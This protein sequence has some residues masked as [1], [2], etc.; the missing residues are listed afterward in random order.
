MPNLD[1][2]RDRELTPKNS[3]RYAEKVKL[4]NTIREGYRGQSERADDI[5]DFWSIYNCEIDG[6]NFYNGSSNIY[7]P[8]V[9]VGLR[10]LITRLLNQLFPSS[11]RYIDASSSDDELPHAE[12]AL[13]EDYVRRTYLRTDTIPALLLNGLVEGQYN[14]YND[15]NRSSRWVVTRDTIRPHMA[16]QGISNPLQLPDMD[17]EPIEGITIEEVFDQMPCCEVIHDID[18]LV[19]PQTASS[20]D[21]A[22]QQGGD[23]TI[24]RRWTK[25][26]I[27]D[28]MERGELARSPCEKLLEI[29]DSSD[30]NDRWRGTEKDLMDAAGIRIG[31]GGMKVFQV[32]ETWKVVDVPGEGM[33]LTKSY[34]GGYEI[35][36]SDRLNPMWNDRCQLLSAP[37]EKVGSAFKGI[38]RIKSGIASLQ[39]YANQIAQQAADS[40]TYSMLPIVMTDPA[41]NPRT[42]T[43]LLNVGA[44]WEIDPNSTKFAQFPPIWK[45]AT[46]I[47]QDCIAQIFQALGVNP[48]M[49]PQQTG[50]PGRKRNQAETALEQQVDLLSNSGEAAIVEDKILTPTV[51]MW[52]EYDHQF[53][54][55]ESTVRAYGS[56]GQVANMQKVP[57]LQS[58]TRYHFLWNGVQQSRNAAEN[59]QRI[60][61]LNVAMAPPMQQ[62]LVSD[63]KRLRVAPAL[64]SAFG[65]LFGWREGRK[66]LVDISAVTMIKPEEENGM[67]E[68]HFA[69]PVHPMDDFAKHMQIHSQLLQSPDPV[70]SAITRDHMQLHVMQRNQAMMAQQAQQQGPP[71]GQQGGGPTPPMQGGNAAG[72]RLVRG[73]PGSIPPDQMPRAGGVVMPRKM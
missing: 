72:P 33:R 10:A 64:E 52:A 59:Q 50:V 45:D 15:W 51:T 61:L 58:T 17:P 46:A 49:L 22:L 7:V 73:P 11:G 28:K 34:Y 23:V 70:V 9:H 4:Y 36:L 29:S 12:I 27:E 53:R 14:L 48:S 38:S 5:L 30:L 35:V 65:A 62:A 21:H 63:G 3:K 66:I 71:G 41:K 26:T 2:R 55:D 67:I 13:L 20:I 31:D 18:V 44:V 47:I 19:R 1:L 43:M 40:A 24:L 16:I 39:Y 60:A 69:V 37:L 54:D 25:G 42:A 32:Y 68:Q 8:I 56:A 57:L 6:N